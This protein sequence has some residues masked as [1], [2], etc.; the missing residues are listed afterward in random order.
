M[1]VY[2]LRTHQAAHRRVG[3]LELCRWI[4]ANGLEQLFFLKFF[5]LFPKPLNSTGR[6]HEFLFA[7]EKRMALGTNFHADVLFGRSHLD[8]VAAGALD[9]RLLIFGMYVSFHYEFNPLQILCVH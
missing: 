3:Q 8:G 1:V 5:V 4:S 9:G 7:R 6:I 2:H